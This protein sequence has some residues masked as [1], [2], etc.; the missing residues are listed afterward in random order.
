MS[1]AMKPS[2]ALLAL[3]LCTFVP[4]C[5]GVDMEWF[6]D[7]HVDFDALHTYDWLGVRGPPS[8]FVG[9]RVETVL[10]AA[11]DAMAG[12]PFIDVHDSFIIF[13]L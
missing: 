10:D 12:N 4:G 7:P 3:A 11:I 9:K 1:Q 6:H 13:P 5:A 2:N 8:P